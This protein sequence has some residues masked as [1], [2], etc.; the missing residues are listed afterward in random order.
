MVTPFEFATA[1]RIVFGRGVFAQLGAMAK[2]FGLHALIVSGRSAERSERAKRALEQDGVASTS[3]HVAAEPT[4]EDARRG[5]EQARNAHCDLVV[6]IGGGSALGLGKAVAALLTNPGEPLDYLEV[7][8]K[9]RKLERSAAPCIAVPTTAGTGSEVTR[10]AVLDVPD[11]GVKVSLRSHLMLPRVALIDPEL[12]LSVPPAVTASTGFD[13]LSQV[14][15]PYICN[16]AN[17]LTDA[18]CVDA[19]GRSARALR[20]AY[21]IGSDVAAREDLCLVSL[22]G[23]MV[24]A[25]AKLGAV[26]GFAGPLGGMYRG[27]HGA[28]CAALLPHVMRVNLR[29]IRE[30]APESEVLARFQRIA[31]LLTGRHDAEP[32]DGIAFID[33]LARTISLQPLRAFGVVRADFAAICDKAAVASSMQGNPIALTSR[34]LHEIIEAAL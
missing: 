21:E 23:G 29:A 5:V 19:I 13:A 24:L 30:R 12:T 14:I 6:A 8:G 28:I 16:R 3:L 7:V 31:H 26:H 32:E 1:S 25:N 4:T 17:P 10:N 9:G 15:E 18:L 34:E 33:D 2:E 22:I 20:R 27:P 11:R